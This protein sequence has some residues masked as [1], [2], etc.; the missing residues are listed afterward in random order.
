[1]GIEAQARRLNSANAGQ[2][3]SVNACSLIAVPS[4]VGECANHAHRSIKQMAFDCNS[5]KSAPATNNLHAWGL[6]PSDKVQAG[7]QPRA[8]GAYRKMQSPVVLVV[9]KRVSAAP[10]TFLFDKLAVQQHC[11]M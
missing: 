11:F 3:K 2:V 6:I 1:M 7:S 8:H 4:R 9:V 10:V 5:G